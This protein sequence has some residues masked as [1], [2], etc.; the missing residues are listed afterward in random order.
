MEYFTKYLTIIS[1]IIRDKST[2]IVLH[3]DPGNGIT[4]LPDGTHLP[5]RIK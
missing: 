2:I 5:R 3:D 1:S 4:T